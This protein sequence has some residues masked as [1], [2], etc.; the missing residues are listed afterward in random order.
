MQSL[1]S[2][3]A[4]ASRC[5]CRACNSVA[6]SSG[7]RVAPP[8]RK[9]TFAEIFTAAYTSVF[10]SAAVLDSGFKEKRRRELDEQLEETKRDLEALRSKNDAKL[11]PTEYAET[12]KALAWLTDEQTEALWET[13]KL[14]QPWSRH[15]VNDTPLLRPSDLRRRLQNSHYG[16]DGSSLPPLHDRDARNRIDD[17]IIV[18]NYNIPEGQRAPLTQHQV[19]MT[20]MF[21]RKLVKRLMVYVRQSASNRDEYGR[22]KKLSGTAAVVDRMLRNDEH[23]WFV[24]AANDR[25]A[26][27][28]TVVELNKA[29]R[30]V[31]LRT[32]L[33]VQEQVARVCYNLMSSAYPPDQTTLN[34]LI[35][36]FNCRRDLRVFS[37]MVAW[38]N[39]HSTKFMP[40]PTTFAACLHTFRS[41]DSRA[42][43]NWLLRA[44]V[45]ED[46]YTGAKY[47]RRHISQ[48]ETWPSLRAWA[49]DRTRRTQTS[50]WIYAHA[51]LN[52]LIVEQILHGLLWFGSIGSCVTVLGTC[53]ATGVPVAA[54]IVK[55]VFNECINR[56]DWKSSL[57][58]VHHLAHYGRSWWA[59]I[60][61]KDAS[62]VA[63]LID[64][65]YSML[66][67]LGLG[68]SADF[69]SEQRLENL[70]LSKK[71][72][73]T[74][75]EALDQT[76]KALDAQDQVQRMRGPLYLQDA[77][78][79]SRSRSLQ[80]ESLDKELNRAARRVDRLDYHLFDLGA[81]LS[82]PLLIHASNR[83]L[84]AGRELNKEAVEILTALTSTHKY[85]RSAGFG[86]SLPEAWPAGL[87][88]VE[89]HM[90][91]E[92]RLLLSKTRY[93]AVLDYRLNSARPS[94]SETVPD[95]PMAL[96]DLGRT[97]HIQP[98]VPVDV[99][100]WSTSETRKP[101]PMGLKTTE[102]CKRTGKKEKQAI[103]LPTPNLMDRMDWMEAEIRAAKRAYA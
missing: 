99:P 82:G 45:G 43:W 52:A 26:G 102:T 90:S 68:D 34:T 62:S 69:A 51:P 101:A 66:D 75:F 13:L 36:T 17:A 1:W 33:P 16:C 11:L 96:P 50:D 58:L 100:G 5:G 89:S 10:A 97:R 39:F 37:D 14:S 6:F 15:N 29:C 40:T 65:V 53:I 92:Q 67:M 95:E 18:E 84:A 28:R 86:E 94:I 83:A 32:D 38:L 30:S 87:S 41:Y 78:R 47:M 22:R 77:D 23:P 56:L 81:P 7:R 48:L 20:A 27:Q 64:R 60:S 24:N 70:G 73:A 9:P 80:I 103:T 21:F 4:Q 57:S 88:P 63:Y 71:Q 54:R 46:P 91:A 42:N 76:N 44:I 85:D 19:Y 74:L 72:L 49:D 8:R 3:A 79:A 12:Q 25:Q 55:S 31:L 59:L 93:A 98:Q 2:R 61:G 35:S